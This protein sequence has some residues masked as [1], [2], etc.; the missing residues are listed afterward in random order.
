MISQTFGL[1]LA[2]LPEVPPDDEAL[3]PEARAFL[4]DSLPLSHRPYSATSALTLRHE[5]DRHFA[6]EARAAG[7]GLGLKVHKTRLGPIPGLSVTTGGGK[8]G[9]FH[10]FGGGHANGAPESDL[11]IMGGLACRLGVTVAARW[12]PRRAAIS[13]T[14]I[15]A[16][17]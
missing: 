15:L 13:K 5:F 4:S 16:S 6:A 7:K 17:R 9:L 8:P 3:S 2:P 11:G 1:R 10:L 14:G 12:R